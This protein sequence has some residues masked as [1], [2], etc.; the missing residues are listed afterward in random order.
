MNNLLR[1][2]GNRLLWLPIMVFGVTVL[3]FFLMSLSPIDPA[4]S[5][6]GENA[7]PDQLEAYRVE[8]G[9]ND[10]L[11]VRY[12]D[13]MAGFFHGDL[14]T[15]GP[16]NQSVSARI[17]TALPITL[18]LG[19]FGF[20]IAI[21]ASAILGVVSALYRDR[22]PD[23]VIRIFSIACIATPSFWLSVLFILLFSSTLHLLP[24]SGPCLRSRQIPADGLRV[25]QCPASPL[26]FR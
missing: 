6:L 13:Y 1:L 14:G 16:S 2:I 8:H 26:P 11:I 4:F 20:I 21:V 22:W 3:V 19:F 7:S 18:Q 23:Q 15:F 25:W 5:A 10:P 9:L 17:A 24:A 12:G